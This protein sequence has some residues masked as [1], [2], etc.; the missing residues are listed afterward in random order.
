MGLLPLIPSA[1]PSAWTADAAGGGRQQCPLPDPD[2]NPGPCRFCGQPPAGWQAPFHRNGDHADDTPE[3]IV[4][5]CPLCHLAQHLNRPTIEQEAVLVW[6]PEMTQGVLN[7][8]VRGI[9][10]ILHAHGEP[11]PL[12]RRPRAETDAVFAAYAA[13]KALQDR[14]AAARARFGTTSPRQL[15][16][17]LLALSPAA[18]ADRAERLGGVRLLPRGRLF[19]GGDDIYPEILAAWAAVRSNGTGAPS[20]AAQPG[21]PA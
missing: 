4:A 14:S 8:L 13:H 20:V 1:H 9:H 2:P 11:A 18:Y 15:G 7:G 21:S 17:A 5:A 10:L 12:E 6:L 3:N 16:A 19:R